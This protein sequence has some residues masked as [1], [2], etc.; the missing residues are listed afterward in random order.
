TWYIIQPANEEVKAALLEPYDWLD[1]NTRKWQDILQQIT[2]RTKVL[3]WSHSRFR[4][5]QILSESR[6]SAA[7]ASKVIKWYKNV[8]YLHSYSYSIGYM[9]SWLANLLK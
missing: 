8:L 5:Y 1:F 3:L 4:T 2:K 7:N 6:P 9:D